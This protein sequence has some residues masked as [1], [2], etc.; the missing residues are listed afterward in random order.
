MPRC[1]WQAQQWFTAN[2]NDIVTQSKHQHLGACVP[3]NATVSGKLT[4][5]Y[6][7]KQTNELYATLGSEIALVRYSYSCMDHRSSFLQACS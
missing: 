2:G 5:S 6:D 1:T 7:T 3:Y 4:R